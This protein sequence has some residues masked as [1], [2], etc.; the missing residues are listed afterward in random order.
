VHQ[1]D[2]TLRTQAIV[3][4][5]DIYSSTILYAVIQV[6]L[7]KGAAEDKEITQ[8]DIVTAFLQSRIEEELYLKLLK[9]FTM[10]KNR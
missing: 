9:H 5:D 7:W 6:V 1:T 3:F 10:A 4:A 2:L 8:L